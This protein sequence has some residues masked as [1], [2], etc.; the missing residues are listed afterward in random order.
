MHLFKESW[1]NFYNSS[2]NRFRKLHSLHHGDNRPTYTFFFSG[3]VRVESGRH[4]NNEQIQEV[5]KEAKNMIE[6]HNMTKDWSRKKWK[7]GVSVRK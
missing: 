7:Q 4:L 1:N 5:N 6:E 3:F 2:F